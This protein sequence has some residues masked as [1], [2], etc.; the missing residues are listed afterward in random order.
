MDTEIVIK[1]YGEEEE[2]SSD[3][4]GVVLLLRQRVW[5]R[6]DFGAASKSQALQMSCLPQEVIHRQRH[7]NSRPSGSQGDR[8]EVCIFITSMFRIPSFYVQILYASLEIF[9][10]FFLFVLNFLLLVFSVLLWWLLEWRVFCITCVVSR[11][12]MWSLG[13]ICVNYLIVMSGG[14]SLAEG[15]SKLWIWILILAPAVCC[16]GG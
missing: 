4:E 16:K 3:F 8:H 2:E 11:Y 14:G 5:G 15:G 7:A 10:F 12:R 6:E 9:L 1:I 13:L